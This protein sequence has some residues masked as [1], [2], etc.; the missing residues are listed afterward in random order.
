MIE[1]KHLKKAFNGVTVL[2]D[3]NATIHKGDVISIIGPSGTGKSTFLRCLNLLEQPDSGEIIVDGSNI[4]EANTD[5][6]QM[7]RKMG[8]VFQQFNL[9]GHLTVLENITMAPCSL[10][11]KTKEE[12][13]AKAKELLKLVGLANKADALPSELSGGQQQRVAIARALMNEPPVLFADEPTGNLD[14]RS[15]VEIMELFTELSNE[16]ITIVMVTHE[17]DIA[18]YARRN[19]VMKDGKILKD[20]VK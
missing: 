5:V 17:D 8:M 18:A 19:I 11:G 13:N 2:K 6:P 4:L 9:F 7:R 3:V 10:L 15:S 14:T 20:V 12:A 16:G 1:V